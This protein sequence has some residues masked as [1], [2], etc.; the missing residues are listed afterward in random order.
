MSTSLRRTLVVAAL[1]AVLAST[2]TLAVSAIV[3]A[4]LSVA[5]LKAPH[6]EWVGTP[7]ATD[8]VVGVKQIW[9]GSRPATG[10]ACIQVDT[11]MA[12][13][14]PNPITPA[15][16]AAWTPYVGPIPPCSPTALPYA[17]CVALPVTPPKALAGADLPG[18]AVIRVRTASGEIQTCSHSNGGWVFDHGLP[19]LGDGW[20]CSRLTPPKFVPST[21]HLRLR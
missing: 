17:D 5:P 12:D 11:T 4:P 1:A 13:L 18:G 15:E 20:N 6:T 14:Y 7:C 9:M 19:L 10:Y 16:A 21:L 2:A 3:T 8:P